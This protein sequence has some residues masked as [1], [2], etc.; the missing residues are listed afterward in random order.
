MVGRVGAVLAVLGVAG[1]FVGVPMILSRHRTAHAVGILQ[2]GCCNIP[3]APRCAAPSMTCQKVFCI[4]G[5]RGNSEQ[6]HEAHLA[7]PATYEYN[8]I[9]EGCNCPSCTK[10]LTSMR[11]VRLD[12]NAACKDCTMSLNT[13]NVLCDCRTGGAARSV[14]RTVTGLGCIGQVCSSSSEQTHQQQRSF[15]TCMPPACASICCSLL[16]ITRL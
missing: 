13:V 16:P 2:P 14:P 9:S 5:L 6:C 4:V 12:I 7:V 3:I 15:D 11:P 8:I 1:V 10:M